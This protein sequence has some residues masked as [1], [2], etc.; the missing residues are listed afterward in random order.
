MAS[1]VER[2]RGTSRALLPLETPTRQMGRSA[3]RSSS[4]N[5]PHASSGRAPVAEHCFVPGRPEHLLPYA[6]FL[7]GCGQHP[8]NVLGLGRAWASLGAIRRPKQVAVERIRR[9]VSASTEPAGETPQVGEHAGP[10]WRP[11]S[12]PSPPPCWPPI[13]H[14][15][16]SKFAVPWPP[17]TAL[18][19]IIS[20]RR[21]LEQPGHRTCHNVQGPRPQEDLGSRT[22]RLRR[23]A[24]DD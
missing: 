14:R 7:P 4:P 9:Q 11:T 24:R 17:S 10:R 19:A 3:L 16:P 23:Q 21:A 12:G 22:R 6:G 15:S 13:A 8:L 20:R 1:T 5:T 18:S 2:A